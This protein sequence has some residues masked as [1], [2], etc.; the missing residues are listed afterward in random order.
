VSVAVAWRFGV[1][2]GSNPGARINDIHGLVDPSNPDLNR[3]PDYRKA[4]G[5][6]CHVEQGDA[7]Y[8]P[9]YWHHAVYSPPGDA[10]QG[11]RNIG[12]NYWYIARMEREQAIQMHPPLPSTSHSG[13]L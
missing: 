6:R 9:S 7:L 1:G 13:E 10:S 5:L 3:F 8:V 11:C 2:H 12:V 4:H